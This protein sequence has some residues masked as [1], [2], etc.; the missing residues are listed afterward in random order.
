MAM[1]PREAK[2]LRQRLRA[3]DAD[4]LARWRRDKKLDKP[5]DDQAK[6]SK[7]TLSIRV[8]YDMLSAL[9]ILAARDGIQPTALAREMLAEGIARAA[10]PEQPLA[11][12]DLAR[13]LIEQA[14]QRLAQPDHA[15]PRT[16]AHTG[17]PL[18]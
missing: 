8:E 11:Q 10:S 13:K 16:S 14:S 6:T 17:Q 15:Y 9:D 3:Y 5:N 18:R 12:L 2:L 4:E 1:N 7:T